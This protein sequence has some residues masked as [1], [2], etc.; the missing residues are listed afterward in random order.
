MVAVLTSYLLTLFF[1]SFVFY[2]FMA[3]NISRVPA[4]GPCSL[5]TMSP[6]LCNRLLTSPFAQ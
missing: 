5:S 4:G 3:L 1:Q 6:A 2:V